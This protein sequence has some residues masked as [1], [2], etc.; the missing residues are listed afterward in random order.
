MWVDPLGTL[1]KVFSQATAYAVEGHENVTFFN[2][3]VYGIGESAPYFYPISFAWRTTPVVLSGLVMALICVIFPQRLR[4]RTERRQ[5]MLEMGLFAILFTVFISLGE[6]KFDR[7]LLPVHLILDLVAALGWFTVF[8]WL[9]H[10][11]ASRWS[12]HARQWGLFGLVSALAAI[13]LIG[14]LQTFPYYLNYY[15]PLLGGSKK[16]PQV[17]MLGWGK[18]W[19]WLRITSTL[20]QP[21]KTW[22]WWPGTA[23]AHSR[24]F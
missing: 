1:G 21:Q 13:Q 4:L 22:R 8:E 17:M 7:Y 6:K 23:T 12:A 9:L 14:V 24:I 2:G 20:S 5:V 19:T 10:R 16:A 3:R 15:N 11:F 18:A